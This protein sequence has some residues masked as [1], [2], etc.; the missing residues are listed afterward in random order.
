MMNGE[1]TAGQLKKLQ[2]AQKHADA[3]GQ[4]IDHF[5]EYSYLLH[6]EPVLNLEEI[7]LTNFVAERLAESVA[8]LE[9]HHLSVHLEETA[10]VFVMAD[11]A[12]LTRIIQ[13]LIRN[14]IQHSNG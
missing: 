8:A 2:T 1:L 9:E 12:S 10:P 3:L 6:A 14:A 11:K 5:F 13:N 4:L 7:N